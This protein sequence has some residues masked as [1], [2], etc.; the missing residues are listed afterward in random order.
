MSEVLF[1]CTDLKDPEN[2]IT[3]TKDKTHLYGIHI[4]SSIGIQYKAIPQYRSL[5]F[6]T[7]QK[8]QKLKE[9]NERLYNKIS[10]YNQIVINNPYKTSIIFYESEVNRMNF[11]IKER[12]AQIEELK[13]ELKTKNETINNQK[14]EIKSLKAI[15]KSMDVKQLSLLGS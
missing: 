15:I 9:E 13:I 2:R 12:D 8:I 10:N 3:V 11:E 14:A 6:Y 5:V 1:E 4:Q 7:I